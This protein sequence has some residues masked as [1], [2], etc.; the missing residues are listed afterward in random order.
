[1]DPSAESL[2]LGQQVHFSVKLKRKSK[3]LDKM[4]YEW[5]GEVTV[6]ER[7]YRVLGTGS[8]GTF[9]IPADIAGDYPASLHLK[10]LGM[11]GLGKVYVLDRNFILNK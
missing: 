5:T 8:E 9:Q 7:S 2:S 4:M 6:S 11:N 1:V 10:V 3:I